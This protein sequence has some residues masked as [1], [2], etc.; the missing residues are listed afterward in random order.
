MKIHNGTEHVVCLE[1][2][3]TLLELGIGET[4]ETDDQ[5]AKGL[6]KARFF[7]GTSPKT[8]TSMHVEKHRHGGRH[9]TTLNIDRT[10]HYS[11]ITSFECDG[12]GD[13]NLV[14]KN[15]AAISLLL[16]GIRVRS[17]EAF[18]AGRCS[19]KETFLPKK[20]LKAIKRLISAKIALAFLVF[21]ILLALA[22]ESTFGVFGLFG[23]ETFFAP[24]SFVFTALAGVVGFIH[25]KS[26]L[27]IRDLKETGV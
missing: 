15:S 23:P 12:T 2:E 6:W 14:I 8:E 18:E 19:T 7:T 4:K 26:F 16:P 17:I 5:E 20:D 25:L 10:T 21:L 9:S 11:A 3:D 22:I 27:K 24:M 1:K 13:I